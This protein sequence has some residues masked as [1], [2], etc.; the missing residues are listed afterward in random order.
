M[1]SFST[2]IGIFLQNLSS[3]YDFLFLFSS[4]NNVLRLISI[5]RVLQL[6]LTFAR[7]P[8]LRIYRVN[9]H[10]SDRISRELY[11]F[12]SSCT[13]EERKY[14][15]CSNLFG[16]R[17]PTIFT[18]SFVPFWEIASLGNNIQHNITPISTLKDID[19]IIYA[20]SLVYD[21]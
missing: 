16:S 19:V 6:D 1:S 13:T 8:F 11:A 17:L 3:L 9:M 2:I 12:D 14:S 18:S 20:F 21:T 15:T 7:D 10:S 5:S 4:P